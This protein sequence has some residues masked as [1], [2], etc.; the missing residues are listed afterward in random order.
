MQSGGSHSSEESDDEFFVL[1][2][3]V[4]PV[5]VDIEDSTLGD[6]ESD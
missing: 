4:G 2:E 5:R 3:F 6:S 1:G